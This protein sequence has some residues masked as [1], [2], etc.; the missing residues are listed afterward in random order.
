MNCTKCQGLMVEEP[1]NDSFVRLNGWRCVNCGAL[2]DSVI[3]DNQGR[4]R[5]RRTPSDASEFVSDNEPMPP[6][7]MNPL[8]P[9][10]GD[11]RKALS[12]VRIVGSCCSTPADGQR[13]NTLIQSLLNEGNSVELDFHGVKL[14]TSSFYRA[15]IG[16]LT[17][18]FPEDFVQAHLS[19]CGLSEGMTEGLEFLTAG[20]PK[21]N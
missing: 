4:H 20:I 5:R 12:V 3:G 2:F 19:V 13:V 11:F 21:P 9:D 6:G 7:A 8:G 15:A 18:V 10:R 1:L 14:V 16:D 17:S